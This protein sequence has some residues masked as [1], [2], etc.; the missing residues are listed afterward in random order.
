[1]ALLN[2]SIQ[3][4]ST[5]N[6]KLNLTMKH[7]P[8][9]DIF[10]HASIASKKVI[11]VDK[12]SKKGEKIPCS[13]VFSIFILLNFSSRNLILNFDGS[14]IELLFQRVS[15]VACLFSN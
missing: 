4:P 1:M 14:Y 5:P 9:P 11:E 8:S 13:S 3:T 2:I 7:P 6:M 12:T 10:Q 15:S